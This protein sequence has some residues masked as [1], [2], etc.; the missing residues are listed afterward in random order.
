MVTR[1]WMDNEG[2]RYAGLQFDPQEETM[3]VINRFLIAQLHA[4]VPE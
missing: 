2:S 3:R 4:E 1:T